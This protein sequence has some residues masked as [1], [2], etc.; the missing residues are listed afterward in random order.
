MDNSTVT[1]FNHIAIEQ[2][3]NSALLQH[4]NKQSFKPNDVVLSSATSS[5]YIGFITK[6]L[7]KVTL[8]ASERQF[9]LFYLNAKNNFIINDIDIMLGTP[10]LTSY[11][12]MTDVEIYWVSKS[13]VDRWYVDYP[14]FKDFSF[15]T[16]QINMDSILSKL[17]TINSLVLKDRLFNFLR[18]SALQLESDTFKVLINTLASDLNASVQAISRALNQLEKEFKIN[19]NHKYITICNYY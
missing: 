10:I 4:G 15:L 1:L 14:M 2:G 8:Q 11:T 13:I 17:A 19:R 16:M 9:F 3:F 5:S 18:E 6:G 12:A 7:V